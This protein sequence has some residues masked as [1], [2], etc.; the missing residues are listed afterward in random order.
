MRNSKTIR[1]GA[2]N[3]YNMEDKKLVATL[4]LQVAIRMQVQN[5]Y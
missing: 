2:K 4:K 3:I 1:E 5:E